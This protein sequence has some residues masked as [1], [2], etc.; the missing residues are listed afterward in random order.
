LV[1]WLGGQNFEHGSN[2]LFCAQTND[3]LIS[4]AIKELET[5]AP[6][7]YQEVYDNAGLI[8]GNPGW[9][10]CGIICTL[11]CTE[12]VVLEAIER[13]CNLIVAHHPIVFGGLKK[14]NGSNYV[15]RAVIAAIKNDIA[16][17]AIHTNLDNVLHGVNHRIA[18]KLGLME[19]LVLAPKQ[20]IIYKLFT[21]APQGHYKEIMEALFA[22]GA[23]KIGLYDECSFS[24]LGTGT[25]RPLA[26]AN[27]FKGVIGKKEEG[28][29]VKIEAIFP[30]YLQSKIISALIA[31]HP[32]QTVAYEIIKL[33]NQHQEVGSGIVGRLAGAMEENAFLSMVKKSFGLTLI[34]HTSLLNKPIRTVA[35][36]GG[37]GS[38]LIKNAIATGADAY[39]TADLKYHE[40]FDADSRILLGDI[41]HWESEQFTTDLLAEF[42]QDKFP[43]FAVLKTAVDTNPVR[44]FN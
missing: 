28:T 9:D 37:A 20:G 1:C 32:Y 27:P 8:T 7:V 4:Q 44:Y 14:L 3:M 10:C 16:I 26:G 11:D 6:P 38:F 36:C 40:F 19:R 34:R 42:L 33:E 41:G 22:A 15:E 12:D 35:V 5:L 17:Y 13:K 29:E 25:Y 31:A 18:D 30:Y 24:T 21:Y 2:A 23:G 43:T 39:L